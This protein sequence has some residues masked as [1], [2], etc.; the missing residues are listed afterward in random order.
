M[1]TLAGIAVAWGFDV[2]A[3]TMGAA[4]S[5]ALFVGRFHPL[6]VHLPIGMLVL[7][8]CLELGTLLSKGRI[9]AAPVLPVVLP[10]AFASSVVAFVAGTQLS[11]A[12][13]YDD[14]LL[15]LHRCFALAAV[16]GVGA[17]LLAWLFVARGAPRAIYRVTLACALAL[18]SIGAHFGGTMTHGEGYLTAFAPGFGRSGRDPEADAPAIDAGRAAEPRLFDDVVGPMLRDRCVSCHGPDKAK[19]GLRVD[20]LDALAK[21]GKSGPG[22]VP[23]DAAKGAVLERVR[24]PSSAEGHM[25][26]AGKP[27]LSEAEVEI[28][29]AWID[30]GAN[31]ETKVSDVLISPAAVAQLESVLRRAPAAPSKADVSENPPAAPETVVDAP[32][33]ASSSPD[34]SASSSPDASAAASISPEAP[35]VAPA[36][37]SS[38][39]A[40]PPAPSAAPGRQDERRAYADVIAPLLAKKCV[41][42]HGAKKHGGG[43]RVDSIAA[44]R[45]GGDS[46]AA[47]VPFDTSRGELLRRVRL[48]LDDEEHMPPTD[49]SQ[50]GANDVRLLEAW[51]AHG[52]TADLPASKLAAS[53]ARP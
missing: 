47:I 24:R 17:M 22:I 41:R 53:P 14:D 5:V 35:R 13:G 43:L 51:I 44:L 20:S 27:Q 18:L 30:R 26:P 12:G 29:R 48:P 33:A 38:V 4:S 34:A 39:A 40:P 2:A 6:V 21:G 1:A 45:T 15:T 10:I 31:A 25:P 3:T 8:A 46:G 50:L 52:A 32:A 28:L 42:C 7:V 16:V 37:A 36:S 49:A 9:D 19:G 11:R 23:G